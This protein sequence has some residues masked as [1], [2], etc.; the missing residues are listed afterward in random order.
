MTVPMN[1]MAVY[2]LN[3]RVQIPWTSTIVMK[4]TKMA[5]NAVLVGTLGRYPQNERTSGHVSAV[6]C[7]RH[8]FRSSKLP[9]KQRNCSNSWL[10]SIAM[11]AGS[12]ERWPGGC[13][14]LPLATE[15]GSLQ[16]AAGGP[17]I[18]NAGSKLPLAKA[19]SILRD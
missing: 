8:F 10:M 16:L 9:F 6:H 3:R 11:A 15:R 13:V 18:K 17:A 4:T 7:E 12:R 2:F 5:A 14:P 19:P 1:I